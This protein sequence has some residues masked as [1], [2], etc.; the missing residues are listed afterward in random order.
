MTFLIEPNERGDKRQEAEVGTVEFVE[1]REETAVPL[2]LVEETFDQMPFFVEMTVIVS[3]LLAILA[4]RND[5]R[6]PDLLNQFEHSGGVI[7]GVGNDVLHRVRH[8]RR[9]QRWRLGHIVALSRREQ[10][11]Q[12]IAQGIHDHMQLAAEPAAT[13][14]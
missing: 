7:T 8:V 1:A 3:G 13:A 9:Q 6:G 11:V 5:W 10:T 14:A 2:D 4:G 12:G